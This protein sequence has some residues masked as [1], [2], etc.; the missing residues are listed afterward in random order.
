MSFT[1]TPSVNAHK[2]IIVSKRLR[3][4]T[5]EDITCVRMKCRERE[6]FH[7]FKKKESGHQMLP[8]KGGP[9]W[10]KEGIWSLY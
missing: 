2:H 1:G 3:E 4:L 6:T 10:E 7:Q 9:I 8:L 5:I